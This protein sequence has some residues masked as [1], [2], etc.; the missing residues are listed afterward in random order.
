M[1][2]AAGAGN[3]SWPQSHYQQLDSFHPPKPTT[4]SKP[5]IIPLVSKS[6]SLCEK[7]VLWTRRR[8]LT[9]AISPIDLARVLSVGCSFLPCFPAICSAGRD[10]KP[11]FRFAPGSDDQRWPHP[12]SLRRNH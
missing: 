5:L 1:E 7:S 2:T 10:L 9:N 12:I 6:A 11:T 4:C 3:D 8:R